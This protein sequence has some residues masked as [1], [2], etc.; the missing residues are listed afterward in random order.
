MLGYEISHAKCA[1]IMRCP[2]RRQRGGVKYIK[3]LEDEVRDR[4]R[5]GEIIGTPKDKV[6]GVTYMAWND[7]VARELGIP[8][9]KVEMKHFE[10]LAKRGFEPKEGECE[11]VT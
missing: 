9:H 4:A 10:E 7:R 6:F 2:Y 11:D 8:Y 1:A 5:K 3:M